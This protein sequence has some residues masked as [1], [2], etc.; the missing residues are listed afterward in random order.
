MKI[1]L[2]VLIVLLSCTQKEKPEINPIHGSWKM[3]EIHYIYSDSTYSMDVAHMGTFLFTPKRYVIM[4]TPW[5]TSRQPFE[6]ISKPKEKEMIA[7]FKTIVFN[8][9]SY[10]QTDSTIT[11]TADIAKVP[12][13]EGGKQFY[14]YSIKNNLLD[15]TM[16]DES[17]PNGDKP[18]WYGKMKVRFVLNR[19]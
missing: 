5:K 15:I 6:D 13:F 10:T 18:A 11:S 12:G 2:F 7:S 9:G 19:E 3:K 1:T 4:Y 16:F 8:S 14:R 17:Y